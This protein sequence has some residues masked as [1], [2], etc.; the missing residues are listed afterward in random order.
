MLPWRIPVCEVYAEPKATQKQLDDS[1]FNVETWLEQ[2]IAG[3]FSYA[4]FTRPRLAKELGISQARV[5]QI[6][7]GVGTAKVT[8]DV[9]F[10]MLVALG[11][12][13]KVVTRTAA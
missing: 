2:K 10:N 7:S 8:F 3:K 12:D 5:A 1:Q 9:L 4:G 11:L 6:E 13:Y